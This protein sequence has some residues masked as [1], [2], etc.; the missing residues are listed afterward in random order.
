MKKNFSVLFFLI[1][2]VIFSQKKYTKEISIITENDLYTST[3]YDRYYTNGLFLSYRYVA[4]EG[5]KNLEKKIF[6]FT[7]GHKMYTPFKAIL[8]NIENHDRPFA[9][10]FYGS[11]GIQKVFKKNNA[12]KTTFQIGV[13]GPSAFGKNLQDF[14]HNI[15]GFKEAVG[16]KYQIKNAIGLNFNVAYTQKLF[17]KTE[18]FFD[19]FWTNRGKIG[20]IDTNISSGFLTRIGFKPLQKLANSIAF[21]TNINN[22]KTAYFRAVESFLFIKPTLKYTLY[23]ATLQGSFLNTGSLVTN[24]LK[25]FV[26]NLQVG[27]QFTAN[28]F[29]FAYIYN[30]HSNKSNNLNATNGHTY[31]TIGIN[32]LLK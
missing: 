7:V 26:F 28:R 25:P 4:K 10:Y 16:W 17:N 31:G 1:S 24:T 23:D 22:T 14:I 20:T 8:V 13:I 9:A 32:Y 27:Y 19:V 6:E 11:F 30:Y 2:V 5:H 3:Y 21:K 29:N 15:Y 18:N 12:L